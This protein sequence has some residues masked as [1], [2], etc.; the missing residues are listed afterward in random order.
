[1]LSNSP[2]AKEACWKSS[3]SIVVYGS[4]LG[5]C[6]PRCWCRCCGWS[7]WCQCR[8]CGRF[9][10]CNH[11]LHCC[12]RHQLLLPLFLLLLAVVVDIFF[13]N[14]VV[15]VSLLVIVAVDVAVVNVVVSVVASFWRGWVK[16][17]IKVDCLLMD[18]SD[19]V[20][21]LRFSFEALFFNASSR[22]KYLVHLTLI[23]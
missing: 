12:R 22:S 6:L 14:L 16:R 9:H 17:S 19:R 15:I 5:I 20:L 11:R 13:V 18:S 3:V 4:V 21:L 1:M 2:V 10:R 7:C 8:R 23:V